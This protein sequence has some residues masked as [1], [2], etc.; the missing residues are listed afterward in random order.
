[1]EPNTARS[2]KARLWASDTWHARGWAIWATLLSLVF[3]E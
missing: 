3:F 2:H 1:M